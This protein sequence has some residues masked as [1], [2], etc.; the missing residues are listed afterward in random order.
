M[1][2]ES[3]VLNATKINPAASYDGIESAL[4]NEGYEVSARKIR[5]VWDTHGISKR[6]QRLRFF[7]PRFSSA[8]EVGDV[9]V[10]KIYPVGENHIYE[11]M[12]LH[13]AVDVASGISFACFLESK[14]SV[15]SMIFLGCEAVALIEEVFGRQVRYVFTDRGHELAGNVETHQFEQML[16][17]NDI[18][19]LYE[20]R[21]GV[22]ARHFTDEVYEKIKKYILFPM[23]K[24]TEPYCADQLKEELAHFMIEHNEQSYKEFKK[25]KGAEYHPTRLRLKVSGESPIGFG[26][27]SGNRPLGLWKFTRKERDSQVWQQGRYNAV[28]RKDGWWYIYSP[29]GQLQA[30]IKYSNGQ[31]EKVS[32]H[33][34]LSASDLGEISMTDLFFIPGLELQKL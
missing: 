14:S 5:N 3:V 7:D 4:R 20:E 17:N 6:P 12:Y 29:S 31:L 9:L 19:H 11:S 23:P 34:T 15:E 13:L 28:G 1:D 10:F 21:N 33:T 2:L 8:S 26:Q 25:K 22:L 18:V 30:K 16:L 27:L 24:L 32:R